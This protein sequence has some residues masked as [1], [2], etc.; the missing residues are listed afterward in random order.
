M[1]LQHEIRTEGKV[2]EQERERQRKK[3]KKEFRKEHKRNM[4]PHEVHQTFFTYIVTQIIKS[5]N[6]SEITKIYVHMLASNLDR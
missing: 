6:K 4:Q 1:V 2:G 5:G 3:E